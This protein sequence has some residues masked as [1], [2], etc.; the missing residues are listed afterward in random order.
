MSRKDRLIVLDFD[1]F[2]VNSYR[3]LQIAFENFGLDIGDEHRFQH[4]RKFLKYIG[5]VP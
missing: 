4:R 2:L 1:G 3:L 5:V